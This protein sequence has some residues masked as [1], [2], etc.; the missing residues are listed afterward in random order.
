MLR[1]LGYAHQ[2]ESL[3]LHGSWVF[4][5]P[6]IAEMDYVPQS[7][8]WSCGVAVALTAARALLKRSLDFETGRALAGADAEV[9]TSNSGLAEALEKIFSGSAYRVVAGALGTAAAEEEREPLRA[10]G[11]PAALARLL[12]ESAFLII[13]FREPETHLGH[14]AAVRGVS[15]AAL[16]L[17]DPYFGHTSVLA[18]EQF[19]WRSGFS[20]PVV[21]G[22]FAAIRHQR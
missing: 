4:L 19:D 16:L 8:S 11:P 10:K 21:H 9:G 15:E 12:R 22:W 5:S 7:D 6:D 13:N 14:F 3:L 1:G 2:P 20:E 18:R 17:S